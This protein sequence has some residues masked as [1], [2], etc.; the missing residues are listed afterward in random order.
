LSRFYVSIDKFADGKIRIE[1]KE[2]HHILDVLRLKRGDK[3]VLFGEDG[4]EYSGFIIETSAKAVIF[5]IDSVT[6]AQSRKNKTRITLAQALPK[7]NKMDLI[8]E[9]ATE[10]GVDTIIP[11]QTERSIVKLRDAGTAKTGR[12]MRIAIEAAKQCGRAD[13][14]TIKEVMD[15]DASLKFV[16]DNDIAL[17]GCLRPQTVS[18]KQILRQADSP[19]SVIL[20]IGPEGDFSDNEVEK[21]VK[22]GC[23]PISLGGL[24]LKTDTAAISALS[25]VNYEL[26]I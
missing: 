19:N 13:V 9:K 17:I 5:S 20:F 16:K 4:K 23:A 26:N 21:A 25:M 8:V 10:L 12:W 2:A 15:F 3:A 18:L 7:K 1:G 22:T 6:D 24:V 11:V 14:S